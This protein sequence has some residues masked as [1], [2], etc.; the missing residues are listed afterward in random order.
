MVDHESLRDH[1]IRDRIS[2]PC[3]HFYVIFPACRLL[4][5]LSGVFC[6]WVPHILISIIRGHGLERVF[7]WSR[8]EWGLLRG[9]LQES[10]PA[11]LRG[12]LPLHMLT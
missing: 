6:S 12:Y 1:R 8:I 5:L 11:F 2:Q 9:L 7:G 4:G 3:P 10:L